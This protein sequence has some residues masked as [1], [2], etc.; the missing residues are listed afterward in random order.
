MKTSL[1][2]LIAFISMTLITCKAQDE[3]IL[4]DHSIR[5]SN[6]ADSPP[7]LILLHGLGSNEADMLQLANYLD[8][9]FLVISARA[10]H[11]VRENSYRWYEVDFSSGKP[12]S[13]KAE[14]MQS[15]E[16]LKDFIQELK[17]IYS[18]DKD[19]VFIGG[20]SQGAIMSF[21]LG[22]T[23]PGLI[24]GIVALSGRLMDHTKDKIKKRQ[25]SNILI[26]HGTQDRVLPISYAREAKALLEESGATLDY[27]EL[28]IGHTVNG[29]TVEL[30]NNWLNK[31]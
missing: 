20:F 11:L 19:K 28:E 1:G 7:L 14:A 10:P 21:D 25:P 5:A 16:I 4:L 22:F 27:H 30:I 8:P 13:N 3:V 24:K 18:F 6:S 15:T 29:Q 23:E 12:I 2:I 26:I 9:R 31:Q 17:S